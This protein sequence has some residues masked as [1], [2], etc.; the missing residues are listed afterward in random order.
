MFF[1]ESVFWKFSQILRD[2]IPNFSPDVRKRGFV[3]V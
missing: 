2:T 3:M 1:L